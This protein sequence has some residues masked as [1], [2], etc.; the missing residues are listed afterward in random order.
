M[1]RVRGGIQLCLGCRE[2]YTYHKE[3]DDIQVSRIASLL[4][5]DT[6]GPLH[7]GVLAHE[8]HGVR[9][10]PLPDTLELIGAHIV[11]GAHE[12]LRILLQEIAQLVVIVL[13]L[14][15]L[16]PLETHFFY[17]LIFLLLLA[18]LRELQLSYLQYAQGKGER[19]ERRNRPNPVIGN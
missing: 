3:G 15:L 18:F 19:R 2:C 1:K 5:V 8:H 12:H 6:D 7:H 14:L 13:L 16:G 11:G 17:S 10:Q 9:P 4:G